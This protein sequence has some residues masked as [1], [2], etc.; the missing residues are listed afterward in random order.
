[1]LIKEPPNIESYSFFRNYTFPEQ[2]TISYLFFKE[3][4]VCSAIWS[5]SCGTQDLSLLCVG[6]LFG[7]WA[8]GHVGS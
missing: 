5:L 3:T 8:P 6:S 1:M 4:F 7:A 2:T